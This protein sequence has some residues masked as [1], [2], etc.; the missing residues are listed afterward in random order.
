M[1]FT[2]HLV[3]VASGQAMKC[4]KGEE[5]EFVM[6]SSFSKKPVKLLYNCGDIIKFG[7]HGNYACLH[8]LYT[9]KLP[10]LGF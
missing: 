4:L 10:R 1:V 9:L 3:H 7:C 6:E 8:I 2:K 5:Q